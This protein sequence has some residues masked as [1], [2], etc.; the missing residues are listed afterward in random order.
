[1]DDFMLGDADY[2]TASPYWTVTPQ[3]GT[4]LFKPV[5]GSLNPADSGADLIYAG[6]GADHV[7]AGAGNDIAFGEGGNDTL[8]GEGGGA[9]N[10][11]DWRA[12]A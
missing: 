1:G 10:D 7:W 5:T 8:I 12:A 9:V 2:Q 6:A 3:T 11:S 4:Y